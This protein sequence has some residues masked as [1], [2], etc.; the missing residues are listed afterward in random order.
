MFFSLRS[1]DYELFCKQKQERVFKSLEF[2]KLLLPFDSRGGGV[3]GE[4]GG[5]ISNY[6]DSPYH[7]SWCG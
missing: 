5:E 3:G 4:V 2:K 6:S 1:F 7:L